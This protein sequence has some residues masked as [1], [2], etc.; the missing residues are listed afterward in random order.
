MSGGSP[1]ERSEEFGTTYD[2]DTMLGIG[3]EQVQRA[4]MIQI[5]E[6]IGEVTAT[7]QAIGDQRDATFQS[8]TGIHVPLITL[9][10]IAAG[11]FFTGSHP[12]LVEAPIDLWPSICVYCRDGQASADQKDQYDSYDVKLYVEFLGIS[13]AVSPTNVKSHEGVL[14]E[15][16]VDRIVQRMGDVL[17]LCI[18][19]D[20]TLGNVLSGPIKNPPSFTQSA[21]FTRRGTK[22]QKVSDGTGDAYVFQGKQFTYTVQKDSY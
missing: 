9:P 1:F 11:N 2:R 7:M 14:A 21:P 19:A 17:V 5:V 13:S 20:R 15:D 18:D 12:S 4:A 3:T 16:E 22:G 8:R 10:T 6:L